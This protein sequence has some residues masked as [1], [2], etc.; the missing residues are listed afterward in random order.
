MI[1]LKGVSISNDNIN[2]L[3]CVKYKQFFSSGNVE[4][5][6]TPGIKRKIVCIDDEYS[7]ICKASDC[8]E[9]KTI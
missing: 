9:K 8:T 3:S 6:I 2:S 1:Y 5:K 7:I 4:K